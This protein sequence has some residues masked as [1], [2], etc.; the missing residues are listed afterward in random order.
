MV[1]WEIEGMTEI[2]LARYEFEIF[3][4]WVIYLE[5]K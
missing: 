2:W 1:N 5:K 3:N 4:G